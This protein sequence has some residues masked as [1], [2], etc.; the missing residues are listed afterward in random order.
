MTTRDKFEYINQQK[1]IYNKQIIEKFMSFIKEVQNE[2]IWQS[3]N[4]YLKNLIDNTNYIDSF[5]YLLDKIDHLIKERKYDEMTVCDTGCG[6]GWAGDLFISRF[7]TNTLYL[8][9]TSPEY[10]Y[11]DIQETCFKSFKKTNREYR[12]GL[13]SDM[14]FKNNSVDI[15]IYNASIHHET[16]MKSAIKEAYRVLNNNGMLLITNEYILTEY[17]FI[18]CFLKKLARLMVYFFKNEDYP[19]AISNSYIEHDGKLGDRLYRRTFLN[20]LMGKQGF[21]NEFCLDTNFKIYKTSQY[22]FSHFAYSK[23]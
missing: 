11:G 12:Q 20:K 18:K 16:N 13:F 1:L 6:V 3:R 23:I 10:T 22:F 5:N 2:A 19:Q 7:A 15:L 17:Q 14:P 4:N 8:L 9:D 21:K